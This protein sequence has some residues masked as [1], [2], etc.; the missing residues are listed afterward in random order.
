MSTVQ[1]GNCIKTNR[2]SI[3]LYTRCS[4]ISVS[5]VSLYTGCSSNYKICLSNKT[6]VSKDKMLSLCLYIRKDK[7]SLIVD[8]QQVSLSCFIIKLIEKNMI[9]IK[10]FQTIPKHTNCKH[11]THTHTY[12]VTHEGLDS[13]DDFTNRSHWVHHLTYILPWIWNL[14]SFFFQNHLVNQ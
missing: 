8:K 12:K 10:Y 5:S 4:M 9:N 3:S 14:S 1:E 2:S 13:R 11:N 7:I 6:V